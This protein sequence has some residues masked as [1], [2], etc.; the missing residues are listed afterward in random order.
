MFPMVPGLGGDFPEAVLAGGGEGVVAKHAE[1]RMVLRALDLRAQS[2]S[3][4]P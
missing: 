3:M 1:G 4:E 2:V